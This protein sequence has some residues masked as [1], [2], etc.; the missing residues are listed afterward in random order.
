VTPATREPETI[1]RFLRLMR[2]RG[3]SDLHLS[4]GRP[5]TFR[6]GGRLDPVRWRVLTDRDYEALVAPVTPEHLWQ[7]FLSKGD[8]GF[9]YEVEGLA[10]FRVKLFRHVR[11]AGAVLRMIP[12]QPLTMRQLGLPA[13]VRK[14]VSLP[15][16]L[17][18]VTGPSGSGKSTTLAAIVDEI[19][20]TRN[21]HLIAIEEPIEFVHDNAQAMISQREI[22]TDAESF[23]DALRGALR[24]DPDAI[25]IGELRDPETIEM[26]LTAAEAGILVFGTLH[27]R[28]AAKAIDRIIGSLPQR[29][30]DG[31]RSMLSGVLKGVVGQ[32]LVPR[33]GGGTVAA[34]EVL[35]GS[36]ALA[37]LIRDRRTTL[38]D[39]V[40]ASGK[41]AGMIRMDD[42]LQELVA[43]DVVA[44]EDAIELAVDRD[45]M[46]KWFAA[47]A[48]VKK[49]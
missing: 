35:F 15:D 31:A 10:R 32:Q 16:G 26:A 13:S 18:L 28:S 5:P 39:N 29:W 11:G 19:N 14:I 3:A 41:S 47:R 44:P 38:V 21:L 40:I 37:S 9:A 23:A 8:V 42:S 30:Q 24:E 1:D 43:Q 17:V 46:A 2:E 22:G 7:R 27:T 34:F 12:P 20:R 6:I 36:P 4:V 25:M 48:A 33:K 49:T 45:A